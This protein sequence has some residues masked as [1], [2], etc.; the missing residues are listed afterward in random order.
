MNRKN[1]SIPG[2]KNPSVSIIVPVYNTEEYLRECLD[3][4][5]NQTLAPSGCLE[6]ILI[7]DG[8]KD[9][10]GAICDEYAAE[11]AWVRVIHQANAGQ[12]AARN[13]GLDIARGEYITFVDSDDWVDLNHMERLLQRARETGAAMV[14]I[15]ALEHYPGGEVYYSPIGAT[16]TDNMPPAVWTKMCRRELIGDLRFPVGLWYEDLAF[17]YALTLRLPENGRVDFPELA[18]H[19]RRRAGSTMY[20]VNV[21]KN[22]DILSIFDIMDEY[23][24]KYTADPQLDEKHRS[25]RRHLY[26][27][28][29]LSHVAQTALNRVAAMPR[30]E[31]RRRVSALIRAYVP[32]RLP[33]WKKHPAYKEFDFNRRLIIRLNLAGFAQ[34][35]RLLMA[36]KQ[37]FTRPPGRKKFRPS[38]TE[39]PKKTEHPAATESPKTTE[40]K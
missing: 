35:S 10:S 8:S 2:N 33:G 20:N 16:P 17:S 1:D 40:S 21:K 14:E 6:L 24:V 4:L 12:A 27:S 39:C 36:A 18:Y 5:V 25:E 23:T 11:H 37:F 26:A 34:I 38:A 29:L 3:S 15:G 7:N 13:R 31:E 9:T 32:M 19:S 28:L 22:L 30:S